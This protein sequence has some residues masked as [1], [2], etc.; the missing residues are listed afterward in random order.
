MGAMSVADWSRWLVVAMGVL[1]EAACDRADDP[2]IG[3]SAAVQFA[4]PVAM[5]DPADP[6]KATFAEARLAPGMTVLAACG[7]LDHVGPG[8]GS[9]VSFDCLYAR[10][11]GQLVGWDL[12]SETS[13]FCGQT[14]FS[15]YAGQVPTG[16]TFIDR[17]GW[18]RI[19]P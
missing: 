6:C 15:V 9:S 8:L 2:G 16:C 13:A 4:C 18:T 19:N 17:P 7:S 14:T 5:A 3:T 10:D 11:D 12:T 1:G